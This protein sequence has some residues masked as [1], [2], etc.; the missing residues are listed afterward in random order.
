MRLHM[1]KGLW[2]A[3][4]KGDSVDAVTVPANL[5][6]WFRVETLGG[7]PEGALG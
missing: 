3:N 7:D 6:L 5:G 1:W 2:T 4:C